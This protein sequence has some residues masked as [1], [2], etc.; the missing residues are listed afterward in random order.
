MILQTSKYPIEFYENFQDFLWNFSF[1]EKTYFLIDSNFYEL[2]RDKFSFLHNNQIFIVPSG[3]EHKNLETLQKIWKFLCDNQADRKSVLV[4]LGGGVVGDMGGF[5]AACF[6]RGIPFIQIP[7]TLL[8]MV[9]SSVGGKTAIDFF[10]FKNIIGAFYFPQKVLICKE[11]LNSLPDRHILAGKAEMFKH[12][13]IND[14]NHLFDLKEI[15]SK[16][17]YHSV[18]IKNHFVEN[19][20]YE[21]NIRKA[22][23]FGHTLGHAFETCALK[24]HQDLLHGEAVWLGMYWEMFYFHQ[25]QWITDEVFYEFFRNIEPFLEKIPFNLNFDFLQRSFNYIIMDKKKAHQEIVFPIVKKLGSFEL[26][27][28]NIQEFLDLL[29]K[30]KP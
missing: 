26:Q 19:D 7:T 5:A 27:S 14:Y 18:K 13:I 30:F 16:S 20:P 17:I 28:V 3:E 11:F 9:D 12:A 29:K 1:N 4:C 25:F 10:N 6:M 15:N 22:L 21:K 23:N 24:N 2:W 8:S